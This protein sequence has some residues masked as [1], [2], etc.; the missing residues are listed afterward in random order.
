MKNIITQL[1]FMA[2][3]LLVSACASYHRLMIGPD[4]SVQDCYATGQG[5]IGMASA[6]KYAN[7]CADNLKRLGYI[8]IEQAGAVGITFRIDSA[9]ALKVEPNSPADKVGIKGGDK[10]IEIN[11]VEVVSAKDAI[12]LLFGEAGT[13]LSITYQ[14]GV[15]RFSSKLVRAFY[16]ELYGRP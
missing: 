3:F 8:E 9:Y 7:E 11:N 16:T 12:M 4:G 1:S 10:I 5:I 2:F 15:N 14:R 13:E 6:S